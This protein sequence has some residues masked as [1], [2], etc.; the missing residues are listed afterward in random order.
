MS[1]AWHHHFTWLGF[2]WVNLGTLYQKY[3]LCIPRSET[4]W[5]RS[6]FLHSC[7]C[8]RFTYIFTGFVCLFGC[9]KIGR[10]RWEYVN[11]SQIH[12]CGNC[13]TEHY[14]SL[15]KYCNKAV[16]FHF[17]EYINQNQTF[18]LHSHWPFICSALLV[19]GVYPGILY[20]WFSC[21]GPGVSICL[22]SGLDRVSK[23]ATYLCSN[24]LVYCN[25]LLR[26]LQRGTGTLY[27]D[28]DLLMVSL[29]SLRLVSRLG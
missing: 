12:L 23:L 20:L 4:V 26:W 5:P 11:C 15:W 28:G 10:P 25:P 27:L 8:E 17:W 2:P 29:Q 24:Q 9:S 16:Q 19:S 14:Y 18:I 13:E 6:Q 21:L 3:D 22:G 1:P 7:V